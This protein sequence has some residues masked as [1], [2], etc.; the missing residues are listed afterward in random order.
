[1]SI[2]P[3]YSAA[4]CHSRLYISTQRGGGWLRCLLLSAANQ[5][6]TVRAVFKPEWRAAPEMHTLRQPI[7]NC[8]RTDREL[9]QHCSDLALLLVTDCATGRRSVGRQG[10]PDAGAVCTPPGAELRLCPVRCALL[11]PCNLA[12]RCLLRLIW[13]FRRF[14]CLIYPLLAVCHRKG[15]SLRSLDAP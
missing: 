12:N 3:C 1:M 13:A 8:L 9:G 4:H 5:A 15:C 2:H 14:V 6:R 11:C 10:D 7:H